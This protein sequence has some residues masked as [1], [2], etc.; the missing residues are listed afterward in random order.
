MAGHKRSVDAGARGA[1][2]DDEVAIEVGEADHS[3]ITSPSMSGWCSV[4]K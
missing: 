3:T 2:K 1:G 4:Q